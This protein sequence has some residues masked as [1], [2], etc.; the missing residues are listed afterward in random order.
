MYRNI[1]DRFVAKE[2][3]QMQDM[4]VNR[5]TLRI[6]ALVIDGA[7]DHSGGISVGK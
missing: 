5:F 4:S 7:V 6:D 2:P 1:A 3:L